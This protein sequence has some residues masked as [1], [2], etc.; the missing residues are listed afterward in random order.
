MSEERSEPCECSEPG[1]C[2]RHQLDKSEFLWNVCNNDEQQRLRW[3]RMAAT[4]HAESGELPGFARRV[5]NFTMAYF[6]Y[7][8]SGRPTRSIDEIN[9]IVDIC[10][11]CEAFN[12]KYCSKI[13]C[14]CPIRRRKW[15][16]KVGWDTEHC[17]DG[18]W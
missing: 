12:G 8:F 2:P 14:G 3:D 1:F 17:P 7:M 13:K 11:Q 6:R 15:L 4:G 5:A 16:S 10:Y 9:R 18:K